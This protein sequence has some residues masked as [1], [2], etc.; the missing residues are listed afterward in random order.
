MRAVVLLSGGVDSATT[1]AVAR[2]FGL[3]VHALSFRYGQTLDV[4]LQRAAALARQF[5]AVDHRV[6]DIGM[7]SIGGSSLLG[8]GAPD[9]D[10]SEIP[11]TYVPARNTIFLSFGLGLA[12]VVGAPYIMFGANAVD[13]SGYPDCRP[14]YVRAFE[15]LANLSTRASVEGRMTFQVLAPLLLLTKGEIISL[16]LRLG[17][18]FALT[19]SCYFPDPEGRACGACDSCLIRLKGFAD[20]GAADPVAYMSG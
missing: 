20:A 12:E 8:E 7:A 15:A 17:V 13:Y 6:I 5:K 16:G 1:L 14:E 11:A 10:G 4:E 3:Q 18:D 2:H 19:H 9:A